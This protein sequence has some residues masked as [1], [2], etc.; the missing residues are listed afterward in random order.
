MRIICPPMPRPLANHL[1]FDSCAT[2]LRMLASNSKL[3]SSARQSFTC[4]FFS[5]KFFC[6]SRLRPSDLAPSGHNFCHVRPS[7]VFHPVHPAHPVFISLQKFSGFR[8]RIYT[9]VIKISFHHNFITFCDKKSFSS[10]K[11][12][13]SAFALRPSFGFRAS[14]QINPVNPVN[15]VNLVPPLSRGLRVWRFKFP[16]LFPPICNAWFSTHQSHSSHSSHPAI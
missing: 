5:N 3:L 9:L 10:Q 13:N 6:K 1:R 8:L 12:N 4:H 11:H 15:P 16:W 2:A 7:S 14:A